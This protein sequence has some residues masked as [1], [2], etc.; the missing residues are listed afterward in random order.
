MSFSYCIH[1]LLVEIGEANE[2]SAELNLGNESLRNF[3][4]EEYMS[5]TS[6][7]SISSEGD[8][9]RNLKCRMKSDIPST[10]T[11]A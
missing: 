4:I 2:V 6:V 5:E 1:F 11:P 3:L 10:C 8:I 7:A 9:F